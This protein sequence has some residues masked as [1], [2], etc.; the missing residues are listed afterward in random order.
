MPDDVSVM[1]FRRDLRVRDLPALAAAARH[2]RCVPVFVFDDRLM[3]RGRFPSPIRTQFMLDCLAEL[4]EALKERGGKLVV[5]RGR[6]EDVLA[7]L[8]DEVGA[9]HLYYTMDVS[10]WARRRDKRMREALEDTLEVHP[11]PGACVVDDPSAIRT[12]QGKPYTVFSP[13]ARNWNGV[14]RRAVVNAPREVRTP[15][16]VKAG[17]LPS[18][19]DLGLE[20][21][22]SRGTFTPGEEAARK[23]LD[24][25]LRSGLGSYSDTRNTP[26]GGSSR[27]SP[28]L[29]W[30]C[31]SPLVIDQRVREHGGSGTSD[32][33]DEVAWR[34]FYAGILLHFPHVTRQEFQER[35]RGTLDWGDPEEHLAEWV[36]GRTGF[37]LVDAGMRQLAH[38]GWMHNRVR[39]VVGS[40]LT[41]DLHLDWREGEAVFMERLLDGD[42]AANN[43]GWQWIASTGADPKPYF[44]RMFN[45]MTQQEKF[46][47]Q[48]DYVK[49]WCPELARVPPKKL[50]KPWT[51]SD[52]EQ[53]RAGCVIGK[54]YPAPIVDHAEERRRAVERYRAVGGD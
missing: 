41:K 32:F 29:R 16:N 53:A 11:M 12:G 37:P 40:F 36:D 10:P 22:P 50:S 54:D 4:S 20:E 46:D 51:M 3:E 39:M 28:Y 1:W 25:F 35:Y 2:E 8:C 47:P 21:P 7:E 38:E 49:K 14:A 23:A 18:L 26:S 24:A 19:A 9:R 43:G 44:Q 45:P 27:L 33:L 13:F 52:E 34:D 31:I 5:R 15:A 30:G 42:M 17:D 48:G 6:P